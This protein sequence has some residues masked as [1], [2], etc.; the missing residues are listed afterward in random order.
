MTGSSSGVSSRLRS[1]PSVSR[2]A[3]SRCCAPSCRLRS[4]RLRSASAVRTSRSRDSSSRS[5]ASALAS[6]NDASCANSVSRSSASAG[7]RSPP[8]AA[9]SS[10]PHTAS[11]TITGVAAPSRSPRRSS[12]V[13]SYSSKRAGR[14]G[15]AHQRERPARAERERRARRERV[16]R[17]PASGDHR[18]GVR[19]AHDRRRAHPAHRAACS[20]MAPNTSSGAAPCATST[21]ISRS[22]DSIMPWGL[23]GA[24]PSRGVE[25]GHEGT[26]HLGRRRLLRDRAAPRERRG[27]SGAP[28][29]S[30]TGRRRARRRVRHGQRR[31]P[32]RAAARA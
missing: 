17:A 24:R 31:P 20:E 21:A 9:S 26:G 28:R 14:P 7:S 12:P 5:R 4:S 6:A 18:A 3:T 11:S 19:E 32:R 30:R 27:G 23:Y 1:I 10:A 22:A 25:P 2:A 29:G 13:R 15:V 16:H 8:N